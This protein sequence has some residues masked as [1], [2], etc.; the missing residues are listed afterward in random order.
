MSRRPPK[1]P[2]KTGIGLF[3][4]ESGGHG[5]IGR[6]LVE[7]G[8]INQEQLEKAISS[9]RRYS[10]RSF[11]KRLISLG[12]ATEEKI[13]KGFGIKAKI[14]YFASLEGLWTADSSKIA[15][16][17]VARKFYIAPLFRIDNVVTGAMANPFDAKAIKNFCNKVGC[18]LDPVVVTSTTLSDALGRIYPKKH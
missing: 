13:M 14:P 18:R 6:I 2:K 8:V 12:F 5:Y 9:V 3:P 11:I 16:E 7:A 4:D 10:D 15:S 17:N 1:P